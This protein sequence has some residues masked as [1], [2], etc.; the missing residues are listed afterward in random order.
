MTREASQQLPDG[1]ELAPPHLPGSPLASLGD[2]DPSGLADL[3]AGRAPGAGEGGAGAA[4]GSP[5]AAG[6]D[7]DRA[8]ALISQIARQQLELAFQRE[9]PPAAEPVG[10]EAASASAAA[11]SSG[12]A[13]AAHGGAGAAG[14][15]ATA[16]P[17]GPGAAARGAPAPSRRA[18]GARGGG[19][20][21]PAPALGG[22]GGGGG[23]GPSPA[24]PGESEA[25]DTEQIL[26]PL[27]PPGGAAAAAPPPPGGIP[28]SIVVLS[29]VSMALTSASCVFNTL[30]PIYMVAELKLTMRSL[31]M[32]EGVLE[33]FSYVVR[34]FSGEA[35]VLGC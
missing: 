30:L 5:G 29:C 19:G 34:M 35:G 23:P 3:A 11:S 13:G 31:G 27:L 21:A 26:R 17:L 7:G 12:A 33:A 15:A 14:A 10:A 4:A 22:G 18:A 9:G 8:A 32:F 1:L 28:R 16:H 20:G 24:P 25:T 6:P 2:V